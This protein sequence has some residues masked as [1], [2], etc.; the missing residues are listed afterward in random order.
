[1][2]IDVLLGDALPTPA[3]VAG[4]VVVVIDVLRAAT[5]VVTALANGARAVIPF[6]SVDEPAVFAKQY[7]RNEIRLAGERKML[8]IPGF[9][10]GNSPAEYTP[11]A[12][13]GRTI[14]YSTTNGTV[15]L[16]STIGARVCYF[17]AFIN[18]AAT[19]AAVRALTKSEGDVLIVCAGH[20]KRSTL[21][22]ITCAGRMARGIARGKTAVVWGDG[23]RSAVLIERRFVSDMS[24]LAS[25]ATHARALTAAGFDS[26]VQ[27]CFALDTQPLVVAFHERQLRRHDD[28]VSNGTATGTGAGGT[29]SRGVGSGITKLR[30]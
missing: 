18:C 6:D 12:V 15:A 22:D 23:A 14:L 17:A 7:E 30:S 9:D 27:A 4:K 26:D 16:L 24:R 29:S 1:M 10:L 19:V 11:T 13:K 3:E 8:R 5:T 20:E 2:R 25:E 21:E 28:G